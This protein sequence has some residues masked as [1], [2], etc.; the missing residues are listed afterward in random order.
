MAEI[1]K[2][3]MAKG[4]RIRCV[5]MHDPAENL[6]ETSAHG[7]KYLREIRFAPEGTD[8]QMGVGIYDTGKVSFFSSK[9]E[10]FGILI[11]SKELE[12]VMRGLFELLWEKSAV[13]RPGQG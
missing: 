1:D 6:F 12:K 3:R 5:R 8:Y 7:T 9:K 13:A 4:V 2:A 11:E 10:G